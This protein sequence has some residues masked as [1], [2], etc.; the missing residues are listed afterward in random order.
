MAD[1]AAD[2]APDPWP[3][4]VA[5]MQSWHMDVNHPEERRLAREWVEYVDANRYY[6]QAVFLPYTVDNVRGTLLGFFIL[7]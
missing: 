4:V 7:F 2:A 5:Y 6:T 3:R 1:P